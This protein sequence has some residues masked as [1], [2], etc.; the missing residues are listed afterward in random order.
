MAENNEEFPSPFPRVQ[1]DTGVLVCSIN[2]PKPK[3]NQFVMIQNTEREVHKLIN[4]IVAA[5]LSDN[6]CAVNCTIFPCEM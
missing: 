4:L 5:L 3:D 6:C 1:G 2:C